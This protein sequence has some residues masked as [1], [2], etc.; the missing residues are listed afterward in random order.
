MQ[1]QKGGGLPANLE[2]YK[3]IKKLGFSGN[4]LRHRTWW[5]FARFVSVAAKPAS[6]GA[7]LRNPL[8]HRTWWGETRFPP[9]SNMVGVHQA[10]GY[11][12]GLVLKVDEM[13]KGS[14]NYDFFLS[15]PP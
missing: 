4:F 6:S 12:A 13:L 9:S 3:I 7:P 2:P 15:A 11:A 14:S 10:R 8:R 5:G 1:A